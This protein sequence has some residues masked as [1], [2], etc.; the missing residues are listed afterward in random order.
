MTM[1]FLGFFMN[2]STR[3]EFVAPIEADDATTA[4]MEF[5]S[6]Y[7]ESRFQLLT[8][9]SRKELEHVLSGIDRWPATPIK[10]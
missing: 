8:V 6:A 4:R 5:Y 1:T 10:P 2:R 9:Y 3:E 7:P